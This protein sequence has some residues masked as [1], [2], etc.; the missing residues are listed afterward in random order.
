[1]QKGT[2]ALLLVVPITDRAPELARQI[3]TPIPE[4][5]AYFFTPRRSQPAWSLQLPAVPASFVTLP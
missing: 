2:T 4:V 1:M 3:T 5:L